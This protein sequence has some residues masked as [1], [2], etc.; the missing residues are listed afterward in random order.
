M[1]ALKQVSTP[2]APGAIGPYSQA[3]QAG[4]FL[5]LSGQIP[6]DPATGTV[7]AGGIAEQTHQVLKNIGAVL[8]AAGSSYAQVVKTTV[9]L[10][11]MA[12]FAV[13][14][15]IYGGYFSAPAPARSTIQ[16][17][18]LPRAVRVEI[19]CVAYLK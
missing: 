7:V 2:N 17:A 1:P 13:M 5:F 4:D 15:E 14:N 9:F 12:D 18:G 19:D 8:S 3:L 6:L 11:D 10:Q 16:A